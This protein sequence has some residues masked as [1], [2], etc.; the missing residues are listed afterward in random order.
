M[1]HTSV[2]KIPKVRGKLISANQIP[3]LRF[4]DL[5]F[6]FQNLIVL[7]GLRFFPALPEFNKMARYVPRQS[8]T[9]ETIVSSVIEFTH[10]SGAFR[11]ASIRSA[12]LSKQPSFPVSIYTLPSRIAADDISASEIMPQLGV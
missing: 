9:S 12:A 6:C 3:A 4:R 8:D 2:F 10:T 1:P 11:A 7:G 5:R